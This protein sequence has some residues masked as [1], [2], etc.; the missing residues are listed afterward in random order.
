MAWVP[1]SIIII[2]NFTVSNVLLVIHVVPQGSILGP[3][4]FSIYVSGFYKYL[5]KCCLHH[6]TDD[7]Q[8]FPSWP[9]EN[10]A[11]LNYT[12]YNDLISLLNIDKAKILINIRLLFLVPKVNVQLPKPKLL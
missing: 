10:L 2:V 12:L 8:V 5:E 11:L 3:M 1:Y 9:F 7:S 4:L 6:C